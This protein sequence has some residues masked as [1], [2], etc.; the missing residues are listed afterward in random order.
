M[1]ESAWYVIALLGGFDLIL[2]GWP[3]LL[4]INIHKHYDKDKK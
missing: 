4:T 2:N 1:K 3:K